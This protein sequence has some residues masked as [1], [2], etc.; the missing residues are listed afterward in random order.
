MPF[1]TKTLFLPLGDSALLLALP[2]LIHVIFDNFLNLFEKFC[3]I[4]NVRVMY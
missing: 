2:L 3:F 1:G 4:C